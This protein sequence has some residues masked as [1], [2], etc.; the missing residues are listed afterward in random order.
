MILGL[1]VSTA[2]IGITIL[3]IQGNFQ[4]ASYIDLSK[5]NNTFKK[6]DLVKVRLKA[7]QDKFNISKIF[8]EDR[9][10]SFA[11][12]FS[13]A[14]T[15]NKLVAFN[16]ITSLLTYQIFKLEPQYINPNTARKLVIGKARDKTLDTKEMV[17]IWAKSKYDKIY[18][19]EYTRN[20]TDKKFNYDVADSMVIA[21]AG[22]KLLENLSV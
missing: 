20:M 19:W 2:T 10:Q 15:L 9:L 7:V 3:D 8:I 4:T 5:E 11:K 12:G 21:H 1:D 22:F 13:N 16:A 18:N 14:T 17:L 6:S